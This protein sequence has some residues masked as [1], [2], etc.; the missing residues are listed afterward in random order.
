MMR[1]TPLRDGESRTM[2][3][4]AVVSHHRYA[5]GAGRFFRVRVDGRPT[6]W[7]L[8]TLAEARSLAEMLCRQS[9]GASK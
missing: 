2:D 4:R 9:Q 1:W 7:T 3:G 6:S 8:D 5:R